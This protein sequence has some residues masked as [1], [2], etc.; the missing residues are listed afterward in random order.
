M[1]ATWLLGQ[2]RKPSNAFFWT[3]LIVVS[4]SLLLIKNILWPTDFQFVYRDTNYQL[5]AAINAQ[6]C[7]SRHFIDP[8]I[9][10]NIRSGKVTDHTPLF[11][12][13]KFNLMPLDQ[14]CVQHIKD[15]PTTVKLVKNLD[16]AEGLPL[17]WLDKAMISTFGNMTFLQFAIA[18]RLL[19]IMLI[20]VFTFYLLSLGVRWP[21]V[22]VVNLLAI[23]SN[24]NPNI[25]ALNIHGFVL[26]GML[27]IVAIYGLLMRYGLYRHWRYSIP[28]LVI[29]SALELWL[30]YGRSSLLFSLL[31]INFAYLFY[32]L[33]ESAT[34]FKGCLIFLVVKILTISC[35]CYLVAVE[36]GP[37][38]LT[39]THPVIHSVVL[40]L[41]TPKNALSEREKIIWNDF[42]GLKI[43]Q[44][45][46]PRIDTL[47]TTAYNS[48]LLSYYSSLWKNNT[49]EMLRVYY[50]KFYYVTQYIIK[51]L[52]QNTT[53]YYSINLT[54]LL[55]PFTLLNGF[56]ALF[57]MLSAS[58]YF[59]Y[60]FVLQRC[61][62]MY[63][64]FSVTLLAFLNL[65]EN[66]LVSSVFSVRF[67]TIFI[68]GFLVWVY[69]FWGSVIYGGVLLLR[70]KFVK[71]V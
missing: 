1:I 41:A 66:A 40:G 18:M 43:A 67:Q 22:W 48:A 61:G 15:M 4:T 68:F 53:R 26:P 50:L 58:V 27:A 36:L 11:D 8:Q 44:R 3:L 38:S 24:V 19:Q 55:Y 71:G 60:K 23:F 35:L 45:I 25:Q 64:L 21:T 20:G 70:K 47:Y 5:S 33:K 51:G 52:A 12:L 37:I 69:I 31:A 65:A 63:M 9:A 62:I 6:L 34:K 49:Q 42:V 16:I 14:Y 46:D 30:F 10:I 7:H 39:R 57:L 59:A 2:P 32:V 54:G 17:Y 13:P 29:S 28:L 56:I